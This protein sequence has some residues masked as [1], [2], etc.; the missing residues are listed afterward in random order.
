MTS[1]SQVHQDFYF[2]QMAD[3]QFGIF[4]N[5]SGADEAKIERA[6]LTRLIVR[7]APKMTGFAPETKLYTEAI[8]ATNRLRP[9]F[10]VMCGD[11]T[12]DASDEAQLAELMRITPQLDKDIPMNWVAGNHD[13]GNDLTP[14]SLALYRQRYGNDNY[15]FDH[16]GSR[17]IILN[18]N[19]AFYPPN[20][21][22][23]WERQQEFLTSA[24]KGAR[25]TES[26]H[27]LVFTHHPLFLESPDEEDSLLTIP[28]ERRRV[29]LDLL[30]N[31]GASAMF[32][33]HWHRNNYARDGDFLMVTS[34]AVGY[35]LGY[36]PSGFRIVKVFEDRI[37]HE[38]FG[39]DDMPEAVDMGR[40]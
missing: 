12:N 6:L 16:H 33:G 34:A 23:E 21:P 9:E 37:E 1:T 20:I 27:I 2:I 13:V 7:P 4:A 3:I 31:Y 14:G 40:A 19:V 25:D 15:F 28:K 22:G 24:L 10:V 39:F 11:M 8:A 38:Y 26:N 32:S 17:F 5:L 18:S 35:P 29:I 36:D 30:H